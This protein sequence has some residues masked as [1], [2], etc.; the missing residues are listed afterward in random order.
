MNAI[1]RSKSHH[2]ILA[3]RF[4]HSS[5]RNYR[6]ARYFLEQGDIKAEAA[7]NFQACGRYLSRVAR[8]ELFAALALKEVE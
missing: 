6:N 2:E 8:E 3:C 1:V 7:I 4:Q 5:A